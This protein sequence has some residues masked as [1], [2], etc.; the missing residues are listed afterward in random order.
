MKPD[1]S[2]SV[3]ADSATSYFGSDILDSVRSVTDKYGTVQSSYDY[4]AFGSPYL[5]NL[6]NDIGFGYC[7]KVYD[8]GTGL[9]DYGFRDY[10]P[11]SAHFTTVAPIRDGSNWFSYV[12]NDPINYVDPFGLSVTD[13]GFSNSSFNITFSS[14][15]LGKTNYGFTD[16]AV[17]TS[18]QTSNRQQT[19]N[20]LFSSAYSAPYNYGTGKYGSFPTFAGINSGNTV[21]DV[22]VNTFVGTYNLAAG[23]LNTL[24][25]S[26]GAWKEFFSDVQEKIDNVCF[27]QFGMDSSQLLFVLGVSGGLEQAAVELNN[28]RTWKTLANASKVFGNTFGGQ[29]YNGTRNLNMDFIN[30]KGESTLNTHAIKHGY[31]SPEQYLRDARNFLEKNPTSTTQTFVSNGNTYFRYDTTANEFGIINEYGGIS[32]YFKPEEGIKYWIE[33]I[34]RYP[35]K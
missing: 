12:V 14:G 34:Q 1:Y 5:G 32:T 3:S 26:I 33:Q 17:N 15:V 16:F 2:S 9:Y 23:M 29:L 22:T 10:S 4:D 7:G 25:N 8:N 28:I 13:S 35:L 6:E 31:T 20:S 27:E 21:L 19:G 24:D 30:G 11:V 18:N